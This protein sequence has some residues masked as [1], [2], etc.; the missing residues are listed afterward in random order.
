MTTGKQVGN[1]DTAL[2]SLFSY[3]R[4]QI[5]YLYIKLL[6]LKGEPHELALGMAVGVFVGMMPILPFQIALAV[7]LALCLRASKITAAI[8]TWVS[9]PL[10]WYF[11]YLYDY[12]LGAYLLGIEGG[13]EIIKKIMA[14]IQRH[15]DIAI[16]WNMLF[17]SGT[18]IVFALLL[19]GIIIGT[20][21]AVPAYFVFLFLFQKVK[22]WQQRRKQKKAARVNRKQ[23]I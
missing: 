18:G 5:R 13:H 7:T 23:G 1:K 8:G 17:S 4:R 12:K 2:N 20:V 15:D 9:N 10:N 21:S 11:V 16:T 3:L 22:E 19:G 14:S 6:R